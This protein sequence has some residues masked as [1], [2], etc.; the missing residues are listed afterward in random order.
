MSEALTQA[1]GHQVFLG[2]GGPGAAVA[3]PMARQHGG[4]HGVL[5][6][7]QLRQQVKELE[8]EAELEITQGGA[9]GLGQVPG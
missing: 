6:C 5:Q 8:D 9:L 4:Q 7:R 3:G 2:A 1:E